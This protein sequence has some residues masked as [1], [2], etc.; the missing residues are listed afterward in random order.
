[1]T[2]KGLKEYK[3]EG[4]P[5]VKSTLSQMHQRRCFK[6]VVVAK[7]NQLERVRAQEGLMLLTR[8]RIRKV[9]GRLAYNGKPTQDWIWKEDKYSP[10]VANESLMITCAIYA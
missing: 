10:T 9:K 1:M 7:L 6:A 5:V 8:K 3:E 4:P 2:G